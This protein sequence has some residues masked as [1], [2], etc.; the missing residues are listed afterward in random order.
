MDP[1]IQP[2]INRGNPVVFFDITIAGNSAG[3]IKM[4]LFADI[5]PKTAENFRQ[6]CTGEHKKNSLPIG[7]KNC[8]FH[9]VIKSFMIQGGDFISGDGTGRIS[10]YGDSFPDENFT[11]RHTGPGCVALFG[12]QKLSLIWFLDYCPWRT[13]EQTQMAAS[14]LSHASSVIGWTVR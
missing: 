10:I 2:A 3:R 11:L 7:Y 5:C 13:L 4:E 14:S 8:V 6:F 9:R 12:N 1:A